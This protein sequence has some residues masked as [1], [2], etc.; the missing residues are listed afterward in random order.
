MLWVS[1]MK[2]AQGMD[3]LWTTLLHAQELMTNTKWTLC[4]SI[5]LLVAY[6]VC[7]VV[8]VLVFVFLFC[9]VYFDIWFGVYVCV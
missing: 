4:L 7:F 8:V 2:H 5:F 6:F 9:F 1:P 3:G